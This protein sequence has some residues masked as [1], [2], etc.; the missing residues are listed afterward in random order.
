MDEICT[1][2][3]FP[4]VICHRSMYGMGSSYNQ[5][6]SRKVGYVD[7][8]DAKSWDCWTYSFRD[9]RSQET[10]GSVSVQVPHTKT[11]Y[12]KDPPEPSRYFQQLLDNLT[13]QASAITSAATVKK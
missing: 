13:S 1:V 3:K 2:K 4:N 11:G 12:R 6:L 5:R 7:I 9:K 8:V 10:L